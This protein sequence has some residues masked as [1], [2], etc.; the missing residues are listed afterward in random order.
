MRD[1]HPRDRHDIYHN[2]QFEFLAPWSLSAHGSSTQSFWQSTDPQASSLSEYLKYQPPLGMLL[3]KFNG[4]TALVFYGKCN[5]AIPIFPHS[6]S[7]TQT[8]P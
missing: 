4:L 3:H 2:V 5:G 7:L 1:T 8:V 6:A